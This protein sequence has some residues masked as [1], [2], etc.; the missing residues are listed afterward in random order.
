MKVPLLEGVPDKYVLGTG[1][2]LFWLNKMK[3]LDL[4]YE[5]ITAEMENRGFKPNRALV[6]DVSLAKK[7]NL[8]NDWAPDQAALNIIIA[9]IRQRIEQKRH[10]YRYYRVPITQEWLDSIYHLS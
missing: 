6:F 8:Y 1:H 3:Y 7:L 10:L 9:R 2:M 4:R 5:A